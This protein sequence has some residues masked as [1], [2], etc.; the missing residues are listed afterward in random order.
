MNDELSRNKWNEASH[1]KELYEYETE[2]V[3]MKF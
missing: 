2:M 1:M 3:I